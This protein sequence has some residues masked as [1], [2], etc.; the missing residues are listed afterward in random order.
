MRKIYQVVKE[1]K[2]VSNN[3]NL[4]YI[5][6]LMNNAESA[7]QIS[8]QDSEFGISSDDY[9]SMICPLCLNFIYKCQTTVCGHNFCT[10]CIDEYLI[11]KKC[12]FICDKTIRN[13]KGSVLSPCYTIDDV[14]SQLIQKCEDSDV[15]V[16]WETQKCEFTKW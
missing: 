3:V 7:A 12:C 14:I 9:K 4:D 16:S 5:R 13:A 15:K 8:K 11:I 1:E 2:L 6:K 10:R